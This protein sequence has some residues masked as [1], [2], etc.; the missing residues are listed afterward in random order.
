MGTNNVPSGNHINR[1]DATYVA[2][3]AAQTQIEF[4]TS[5]RRTTNVG[6]GQNNNPQLTRRIMSQ[7]GNVSTRRSN[8]C[9][10][11]LNL[12]RQ[13][14]T[15]STTIGKLAQECLNDSIIEIKLTKQ[16]YD[17]LDTNTKAYVD[18]Y[19]Q[20]RFGSVTQRAPGW[21]WCAIAM[22]DLGKKAGILPY[23]ANF[24]AVF[25]HVQFAMDNNTWHEIPKGKTLASYSSSMKEGDFIVFNHGGSEHIGM[26][27]KIS[28]NT[29]TT[30][31]GNANQN[32]NNTTDGFIRKQYNLSDLS[33]S[34]CRGYIDNHTKM[35]ITGINAQA[36]HKANNMVRY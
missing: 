13:N 33:R 30:I 22:N 18:R 11:T 16:E 28:G 31:E 9:P 21:A 26:I 7:I 24:T 6:V 27:E 3:S 17:S 19:T 1:N 35:L 25:Q 14:Y 4:T 8:F 20:M 2:P 5:R 12:M 32:G 23:N 15:H 34:K 36:A 29:I 10:E